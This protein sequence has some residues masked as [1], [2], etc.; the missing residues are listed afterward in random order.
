MRHYN[1]THNIKRKLKHYTRRI[2]KGRTSRLL[3]KSKVLGKQ[4][5]KLSKKFIQRGGF[6]RGGGLGDLKHINKND[7]IKMLNK[8]LPEHLEIKEDDNGDHTWNTNFPT[9]PLDYTDT[10]P[11]ASAR[12]TQTARAVNAFSSLRPQRAPLPPPPADA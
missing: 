9:D 1:K 11:V 12:M 8:K 2:K 6:Q 7:Y 5:R 10:K 3:F 4:L